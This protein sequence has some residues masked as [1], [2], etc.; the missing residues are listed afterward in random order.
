M[1]KNEI[2][3]DL[4]AKTLIPSQMSMYQIN[5]QR[6]SKLGFFHSFFMF[7]RSKD[8]D[9][10]PISP[11]LS[12]SLGFPTLEL[13]VAHWPGANSF[14]GKQETL[15]LPSRNRGTG[16]SLQEIEVYIYI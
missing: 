4:I 6:C 3:S 5:I 12:L 2:K 7:L 14:F 15:D 13:V 8:R 16:K 10:F 9:P 11:P 1:F